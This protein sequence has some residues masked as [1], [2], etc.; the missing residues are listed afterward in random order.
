MLSLR[1]SQS[2]SMEGKS[3]PK[4]SSKARKRQNFLDDLSN[5]GAAVR[6]YDEGRAIGPPESVSGAIRYAKNL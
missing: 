4:H 5:S 3:R 1:L 2:G 6:L